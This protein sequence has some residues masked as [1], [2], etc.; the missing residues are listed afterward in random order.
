MSEAKS[1]RNSRE[2]WSDGNV[3]QLREVAGGNTPTGVISLRLARSEDAVRAKAQTERIS[4]APANQP[5]YG[6]MS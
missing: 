5:P 3:Q 1:T 6:D 4:L 2:E